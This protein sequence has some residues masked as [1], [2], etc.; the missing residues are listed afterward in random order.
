MD[1]KGRKK[2]YRPSKK[3][4]G[5]KQHQEVSPF[6]AFSWCLAL[7]HHMTVYME[8][9]TSTYAHFCK[10]PYFSIILLSPNFYIELH[11]SAACVS[12]FPVKNIIYCTE[13]RDVQ[14][15]GRRRY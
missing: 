13:G 8:D 12:Y 6:F 10:V 9:P 2:P 7:S 11:F 1:R 4:K 15:L 14:I 3:G 5:A